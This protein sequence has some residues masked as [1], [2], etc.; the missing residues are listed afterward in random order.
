MSASRAGIAGDSVAARTAQLSAA[1]VISAVA[2][3][4]IVSGDPHTLL[5]AALVLAGA[6]LL[7]RW[8]GLTMLVLLIACQELDPAQGFGGP[9][10]SPLLFLG[11]QVYFTTISRFSLLTLVVLFA[12]AR[13]VV[14][15]R[16]SR[17]RLAGVGLV[18][19]LGAYYAAV[20]WRDGA[21]LTS[22]LNQD[23]RFA[24]LFAACFVIGAGVV[25]T[26]EWTRYAVPTLQ[27]MLSAMA[28]LG[29]YLT[30]TGQD[31]GGGTSLIFYD[32]ALGAIAGAAVLGAVLTPSAER[33]RQVW[34]LAGAGLLVVVLSSRRNIWAAMVVALL[35]GL[36]FAHD[37]M[38]LVLRLLAAAAVACVA[39]ALLF[40]SALAEIGHEFAAIWSATQGSAADASVQGHLS[41]I[42]TGLRAI[43]ASPISGVGPKGQLPGL[44]VEGSGPLYIHNQIL[45]TWLR[46]GLVAMIVLV[47]GQLVLMGQ[48]LLA[49][50]RPR[51]DFMTRWASLLLLM[52]PI[53]MLTAPFLTRTQRWPAVLGLAAGLIAPLRNAVADGP[54]RPAATEDQSS[55]DDAPRA[56]ASLRRRALR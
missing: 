51:I 53:S 56:A 42:S 50:R 32:S 55:P 26:R 13:V 36:M 52:A 9:S 14:A 43:R 20:L 30:L 8:P 23:S 10:A 11:H 19:A 49:M 41:D 39:L 5:A 29:I 15:G 47:A 12:L 46:F 4:L 34:W 44:V 2:A 16:R 35:L 22:A 38:R 28:L 3:W 45:E 17:P 40:P 24:I 31:G 27:V 33:T 1:V 54:L 48:A 25:G 21:S 37:R 18:I 7:L 6:A